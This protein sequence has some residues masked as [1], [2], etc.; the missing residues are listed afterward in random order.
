M[1]WNPMSLF[2]VGDKT[3]VGTRHQ[4]WVRGVDVVCS[5]RHADPKVV[6]AHRPTSVEGRR[7]SCLETLGGWADIR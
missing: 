7:G 3:Y 1:Y 5:G 4:E 6:A 2:P